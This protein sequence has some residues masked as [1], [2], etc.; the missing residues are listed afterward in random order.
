MS[1]GMVCV[2]LKQ[3]KMPCGRQHAEG[4]V[5]PERGLRDGVDRAVADRFDV[6]HSFS[7][8][9]GQ[10]VEA[11]DRDEIVCSASRLAEPGNL[12]AHVIRVAVARTPIEYDEQGRAIV[13]VR[14]DE[15]GGDQ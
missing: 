3:L 2:R 7:N 15:V 10:L 5:A 8:A 14:C 13:T 1:N 12:L 9:L 11:V 4:A 6:A